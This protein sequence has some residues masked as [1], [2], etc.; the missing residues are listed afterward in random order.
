VEGIL[1]PGLSALDVMRATFPAGTLSGAPKIRAM[2][3][4][5]ELEPTKRGLYG[6]A[7][8]YLSFSGEL[9]LAITI[10]TGVLKGGLL[11]V[12][13]AAGIVADSIVENEWLE[14]E[15]KA[16]AVIRAAELAENGLQPAPEGD[17]V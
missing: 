6:G 4:I 11:H 8:G 14:T 16:K 5:D 15:N 17:R 9:D 13:A 10:R 3:I 1:K 12:Q 2:E 7:C